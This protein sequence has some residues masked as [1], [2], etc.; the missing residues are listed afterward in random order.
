M[1]TDFAVL[2]GTRHSNS[3]LACQDFCLAQ[4]QAGRA[5][6]VVSDGCST[7]ALTDLGARAWALAARKCMREADSLLTDP[8][9]LRLLVQGGAA[10][11]LDELEFEDGYATLGIL[12]AHDQRVSATF[13]GDGSLLARHGDGSM[14][15]INLQYSANAPAYLN[16]DR[17]PAVR[18]EWIQYYGGQEL[19]IAASRYDVTGELAQFKVETLPANRPWQWQAHIE[20]DEL[21]LVLIATD[22]VDSREAGSVATAKQLLG[23]RNSA[24]EFLRRRLGRLGREWNAA[25]TLPADDLALAGIWLGSSP[26]QSDVSLPE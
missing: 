12:Q 8:D 25:H 2:T 15:L 14:T 3:A 21:E 10:R 13:F 11:A 18:D 20:R 5:W 24:G 23:V 19:L 17:N 1:H 9:S 26:G 4:A 16:Y 7:G 6:A 22:G